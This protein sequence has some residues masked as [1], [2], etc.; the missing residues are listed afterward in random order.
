MSCLNRGGKKDMKKT[1]NA[2]LAAMLC[3]AA[4]LFSGCGKKGDPVPDL[5]ADI[6]SFAGEEARLYGGALEIGADV[7]GAYAN[8]EY[9]VLE[10]QPEDGEMCAGCPFLAQESARFEASAL[11]PD[12]NASRVQLT[13]RP[14]SQAQSY[15]VRLVGHNAKSGFPEVKSEIM[16]AGAAVEMPLLQE[17]E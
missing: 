16:I 12:K 13:Y 11:W 9:V 6:F 5:S 2:L 15:R 3:A 10:L 14:L 8:V 4:L 17:D 1:F 7:K